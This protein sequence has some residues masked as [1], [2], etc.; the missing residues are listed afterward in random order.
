MAAASAQRASTREA[1]PGGRSSARRHDKQAA[2][3]NQGAAVAP[4]RGFTSSRQ[5]R[6][7]LDA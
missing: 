7:L 5:Q 1:S 4:R 6:H 2:V 3:V